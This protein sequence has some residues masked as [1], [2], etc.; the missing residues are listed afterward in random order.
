VE[1]TAPPR[2]VVRQVYDS[3]ASH[4]AQ[5]YEGVG[6]LPHFYQTRLR[7]VAR[8]LKR[9][10]PGIV[11]DVGSGPG[12]IGDYVRSLGFRYV[13]SDISMGMARE[14]G[15]R[16]KADPGRFSAAA[17]A[18]ALPF[19]DSAFDVVT[20]LGSLEYMEAPDRALAEC[21]RVLR[22]GGLLVVSLLNKSSLYR[23][24]TRLHQQR[25]PA[26][27]PIPAVQ[28]TRKEAEHALTDVGF[29]VRSVAYFDMELLPPAFAENHPRVAQ[30]VAVAL[31]ALPNAPL[32]WLG[33][34][35]LIEAFRL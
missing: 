34:A 26:D 2:A 33:S 32:W 29:G 30:Q 17:T 20:V 35:M 24:L 12:V 25:R 5:L 19:T 13:G 28:F 16:A 1:Q 6:P 8:L 18:D 15:R 31:E 14:C 23:L 11:L 3:I 22:P 27:D 4:Y 21:R 10:Q 9:Q 7:L